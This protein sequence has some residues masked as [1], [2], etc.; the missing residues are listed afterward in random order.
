[1]VTPLAIIIRN[2]TN[3]VHIFKFTHL[4]GVSLI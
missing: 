1:M 3:I 4:V 2:Y